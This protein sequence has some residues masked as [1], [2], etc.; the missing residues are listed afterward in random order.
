MMEEDTKGIDDMKHKR[1]LTELNSFL[2]MSNDY[3]RLVRD[4]FCV[5]A[6]L[7]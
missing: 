6:L 5:A 3:Q 7:N 2:W 4:Y 1:T